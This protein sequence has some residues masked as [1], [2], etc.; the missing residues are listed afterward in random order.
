MSRKVPQRDDKASGQADAGKAFVPEPDAW[1]RFEKAVDKVV[2]APP[3]HRP[4]RTV[5]P[6]VSG[7]ENDRQARADASVGIR[8]PHVLSIPLP[9]GFRPHAAWVEIAAFNEN[10]TGEGHQCPVVLAGAVAIDP[11]EGVILI[12]DDEWCGYLAPTK[13]QIRLAPELTEP[14]TESSDGR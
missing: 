2:K 6:D 11:F 7:P 10:E 9:A 14:P 5:E 3:Q 4:S 12:S 8:L 13:S 1:E